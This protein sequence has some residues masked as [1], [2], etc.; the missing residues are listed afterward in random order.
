MVSNL[1]L[2]V[3]TSVVATAVAAVEAPEEVEITSIITKAV[4]VVA[5]DTREAM[6][7]VSRTQTPTLSVLTSRSTRPRFAD[8]SR[9]MDLAVLPIIAN[10]HTAIMNLETRMM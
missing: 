7:V 9:P 8:T 10:S 3:D 6:E 4:V 2:R 5:L 1:S